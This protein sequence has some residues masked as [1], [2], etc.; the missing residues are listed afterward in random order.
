MS[1]FLGKGLQWKQSCLALLAFVWFVCIGSYTQNWL[2]GFVASSFSDWDTWTSSCT[3]NL[4][5]HSLMRSVH[6]SKVK[7]SKCVQF[8]E[9][10]KCACKHQFWIVQHCLYVLFH[11]GVLFLLFNIQCFLYFQ[12]IHVQPLC[13]MQWQTA[14]CVCNDDF[15]FIVKHQQNQNCA[16]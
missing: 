15:Y 5:H 8:S 13:G 14:A 3:Q 9:H 4:Q 2:L 12:E 1:C 16:C 10:G 6:K 7:G 11:F